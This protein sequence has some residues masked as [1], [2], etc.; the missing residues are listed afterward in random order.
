MPEGGRRKG[1]KEGEGL[2]AGGSALTLGSRREPSASLQT[3]VENK[4]ENPLKGASDSGLCNSNL[5]NIKPAFPGG[6]K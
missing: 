5:N 2:S 1:G 4:R 3:C 6:E